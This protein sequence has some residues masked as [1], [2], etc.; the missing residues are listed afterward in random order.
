M[1]AFETEQTMK[2]YVIGMAPMDGVTD[3]AFRRIVA[4][5]G[6]P[7]VIY[8]EFTPAEGICA[9][10]EKTLDPFI[11][12]NSERPVIAQLFGFR[13]EAF[14]KA[15]FAVCELGFDGIDINMGC[16]AKNVAPKGAGAGLIRNPPLA[17]EIILKVKQ[18]SEDWSEGE[19]ISSVGLP[20]AILEKIKKM[21]RG[22]KIKRR[23][24]PVS[25]KTRIGYEK[26]IITEWIQNLL[27]TKPAAIAIHGRTFKQM[28]G[29]PADWES[30][31]KAADLARGSGTKIFGNGD[32]K[33]LADAK[34]KIKDSGAD[35]ALIGRAVLGNPWIF[36]AKEPGLSEKFAVALEHAE[37]FAELFGLRKFSAM[38]KHLGWY[39]RGFSGAAETRQKLMQTNSPAEVAEILKRAL[40]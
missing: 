23:K 31:K 22:K 9:G 27:E 2:K 40:K 39:C 37:A 38:R 33:D 17:A 32:I 16:P 25:V 15:A 3:A 10:A 26:N 5:Y 36:Q 12:G 19:K 7:D 28:Y 24:I 34:R 8:T 11:Y 30:I 4:K 21:N 35:G 6:K 1:A 14:Y 18:A 13:P 29:G 20:D